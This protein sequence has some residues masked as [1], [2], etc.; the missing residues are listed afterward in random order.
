MPTTKKSDP[1]A[2]FNALAGANDGENWRHVYAR[3]AVVEAL[4]REPR[5]KAFFAHCGKQTGLTTRAKHVAVAADRL[6]RSLALDHR[7]ELFTQD[8]LV[9]VSDLSPRTLAKLEKQKVAVE[10]ACMRFNKGVEGCSKTLLKEA[11][12]FVRKDLGLP[13]PFVVVDLA[14][15][16]VM[17]AWSCASGVPYHR[18]ARLEP[19]PPAAHT[20][21]VTFTSRQ[22]LKRE[23][24]RVE[25][26][27]L[28][29]VKQAATPGGRVPKKKV[30]A[31]RRN[32]R[33]FVR[34]KIGGVSISDLARKHHVAHHGDIICE[35]DRA[36]VQHGIRET[37][38][39]LSL[40]Q[41]LF[42]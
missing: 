11:K 6:A 12:D 3:Q 22:E 41:Y 9:D 20:M 2:I 14:E 13:W 23:S 16:C 30:E 7:R 37:K 21:T 10:A 35:N 8:H 29:S 38:R 19:K 17:G 1:G 24:A 31:V 15:Y 33:W 42:K 39:L 27:G 36:L 32:A 40:A 4:V 34:N 5:V 25:R 18:R 28:E 26:E